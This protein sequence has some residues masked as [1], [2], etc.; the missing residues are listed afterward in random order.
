MMLN[1]SSI[2][3]WKLKRFEKVQIKARF[4]SLISKDLNYNHSSFSKDLR[5][6]PALQGAKSIIMH[7]KNVY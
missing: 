6:G 1:V 7:P 2:L 3:N 4:F 5:D